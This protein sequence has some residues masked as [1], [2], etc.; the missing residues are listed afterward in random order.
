M[1]IDQP[2]DPRRHTA[3]T[4]YVHEPRRRRRRGIE[5]DEEVRLFNDLSSMR[6]R[7][8]CRRGPSPAR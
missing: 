5:N 3:A 2:R 6:I 7:G 8:S 1:N 4:L